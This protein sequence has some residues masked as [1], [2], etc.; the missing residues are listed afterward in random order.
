[1]TRAAILLGLACL[2]MAPFSAATAQDTRSVRVEFA[3]GQSSAEF[4]GR[5]RGRESVDYVLSARGGQRLNVDLSADNGSTYFNI[6]PP[7]GDTAIFIGSSDGNR[8]S[9]LLRQ[10]GEYRIQVYLMRNAAR[11]GESS[12]FTLA[13]AVRGDGPVRPSPGIG[14]RGNWMV[15]GLQPGDRLNLRA[16]P[17]QRFGIIDAVPNGTLLHNLGCEAGGQ[18]EW[19]K[20]SLGNEQGISGWVNRRFIAEIR[21][22][23]GQPQ[24]QPSAPAPQPDFADGLA[25]GP[26]YWMVTGLSGA[27]MLNMRSAPGAG[28]PVVGKLANGMVVRNLGCRMAGG[29]RW[30]QIATGLNERMTGWV[31]GRFLVEAGSPVAPGAPVP[32]QPQRPRPPQEIT[33]LLPCATTLGQP[34]GTCPFRAQRGE[35]GNAAVWIAL[36]SGRERFIEFRGGRVVAT[37]PGLSFAA[38]RVGGLTLVRIGGERYEIADALPFGG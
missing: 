5:L 17:G 11:R 23:P 27:D 13:V 7:R 15:T 10:S 16:G 25:G 18:S 36:P 21:N 35:P 38:E 24:P 12:R 3:R 8:F 31:S 1:M 33:G 30:C 37:D 34:T 6:L 29:G 26:D 9:G 32:V 20:V 4:A 22:A 28:N 14:G 19:C 2:L